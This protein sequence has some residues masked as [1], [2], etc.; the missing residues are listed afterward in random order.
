MRA[1][2]EADRPLTFEDLVKIVSRWQRHPNGC[3]TWPGTVNGHGVPVIHLGARVRSV[4]AVLRE[5]LYGAWPVTPEPCAMVD[6]VHPRHDRR[7][8]R[9][10]SAR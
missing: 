5:T 1:R 3:V 9:S 4:R 10:T 8:R 6:C 7:R 2:R